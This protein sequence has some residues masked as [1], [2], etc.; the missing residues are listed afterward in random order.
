MLSSFLIAHHHLVGQLSIYTV[1]FDSNDPAANPAASGELVA[2]IV[3]DLIAKKN[4][5]VF[6][7]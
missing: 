4:T 3:Q 5:H 1:Q 2:S 6:N 7:V